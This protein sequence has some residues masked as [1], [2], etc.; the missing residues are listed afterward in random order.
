V[1]TAASKLCERR[2]VETASHSPS[3]TT[4]EVGAAAVPVR[5]V[6]VGGPG[7]TTPRSTT[8]CCSMCSSSATM[9]VAEHGITRREWV[10]R[11]RRS[12]R[13]SFF[14]F[15]DCQDRATRVRQCDAEPVSNLQWSD[16]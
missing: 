10:G 3:E 13:Q 6:S 15:R 12:C 16:L 9:S 4:V 7:S 5:S 2:S 8:G 11:R 1:V 14:R